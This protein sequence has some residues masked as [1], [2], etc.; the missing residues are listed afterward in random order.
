[1]I[2]DALDTL[3]STVEIMEILHETDLV[4]ATLVVLDFVFF[5]VLETLLEGGV[6]FK[7]ESIM[8]LPL[9]ILFRPWRRY[10]GYI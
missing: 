10:R 7:P 8:V 6:G 4:D 3:L 5:L 1:M 9:V 2:L